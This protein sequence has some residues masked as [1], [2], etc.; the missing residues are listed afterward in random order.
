MLSIVQRIEEDRIP[1]LA[2]VSESDE[3]DHVEFQSLVIDMSSAQLS[4][5]PSLGGVVQQRMHREGVQVQTLIPGIFDTEH[6][7][8]KEDLSAFGDA[9]TTAAAVPH[10][11]PM[12]IEGELWVASSLWIPSG[13]DEAVEERI[14][15]STLQNALKLAQLMSL[16]SWH[17][18]ADS[19]MEEEEA[20]AGFQER[21]EAI[22]HA[23][24]EPP[25]GEEVGETV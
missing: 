9:L 25:F 3:G 11:K 2:S 13:S 19:V 18:A 7:S 16:N 20:E 10:T 1:C 4:S 22:E 21:M 5:E 12:L 24:G 14:I 15:C 17:R 23:V 8:L 6:T